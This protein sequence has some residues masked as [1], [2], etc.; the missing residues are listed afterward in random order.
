MHNGFLGVYERINLQLPWFFEITIMLSMDPVNL[1]F[2]K[3]LIHSFRSCGALAARGTPPCF[4][5]DVS[6]RLSGGAKTQAYLDIPSFR[7]AA[8]RD[9]SAYKI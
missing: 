6:S 4:R 8:A 9:A 7:N 2:T 5:I 1:G 3:K